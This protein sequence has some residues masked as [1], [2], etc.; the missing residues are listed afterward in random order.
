MYPISLFLPF[1]VLS[2]LVAWQVAFCGMLFVMSEDSLE[3]SIEVAK[4]SF[5]R[6]FIV[7]VGAGGGYL[8]VSWLYTEVAGVVLALILAFLLYGLHIINQYES[9]VILT[10]GKYT[11]I[12]KPGLRWVFPG[13]QQMTVIDMR[14]KVVDVPDQ[15]CITK[16][17]V[18]INVN[19]VLYF[20]I[21]SSEKAVLQV[22]SFARATS[23]LAQTTMRDVVGEVTLDE[24][25]TKR[26][27]VSQRIQK[28]VDVASDKW[29][30]KVQSVDLKHIELPSDMK[31][32]LAKEAEAERERRAVI[33][34]AEGEKIASKNLAEAASILAESEGSL[35]LRTLH[36]LNDLSSDQSNTVIF[37]IPV[38]ILKAFQSVARNNRG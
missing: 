38:E 21:E 18:S 14:I 28:I 37:A 1:L 36:S 30:V 9:G 31:R 25:L 17:N 32:T 20:Y 3:R 24:L 15:D 2:A 5:V 27:E 29:G 4:S 22:E 19:A 13:V 8:L 23:Q 6:G 12:R 11:G 34:K 7:L 33:I 35:H 26:D 10:F 16:D